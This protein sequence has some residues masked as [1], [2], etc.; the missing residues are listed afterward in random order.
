MLKVCRMLKI[1]EILG[2]SQELKKGNDLG[3][4]TDC[5]AF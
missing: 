5:R 2:G 1:K 3:E 4:F